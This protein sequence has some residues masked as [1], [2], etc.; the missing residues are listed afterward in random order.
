MARRSS[1]RVLG[2]ALGG[3]Q[4]GR[5][6]A[7]EL[8]TSGIVY[9]HVFVASTRNCLPRIRHITGAWRYAH[10][11]AEDGG[12]MPRK[13]NGRKRAVTEAR[14]YPA[15]YKCSQTAMWVKGNV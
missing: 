9:R 14:S 6:I 7:V 15:A 2:G 11:N 13:E 3:W 5:P 4:S 8:D 10:V 1:A 12:R